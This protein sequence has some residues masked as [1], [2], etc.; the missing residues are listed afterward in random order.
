MLKATERIR[1][2]AGGN[3]CRQTARECSKTTGMG[4]QCEDDRGSQIRR[5]R[6]KKQDQMTKRMIHA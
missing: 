5:E 4:Q 3:V 2:G 6:K 1:D